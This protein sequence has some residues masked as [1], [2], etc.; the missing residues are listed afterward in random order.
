[1]ME[2]PNVDDDQRLAL[3]RD[4][5]TATIKVEVRRPSTGERRPTIDWRPPTS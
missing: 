1:M 2:E 4:S 5:P 3:P